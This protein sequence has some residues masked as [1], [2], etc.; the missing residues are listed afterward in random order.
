MGYRE[1][2]EVDIGE[3][4]RRWQAGESQRG[5]A[6]ATGV[7]RN[8]VA[9]YLEL[10]GQAG[11]GRERL[12]TEAELASLQAHS[13]LPGRQRGPNEQR[14][15]Q[16][17]AQLKTWVCRERLQLTRVHELL[18]QRLQLRV[19][20]MALYR[21]VV[22]QGWLPSHAGT[23]RMATT[24]PGEVAEVDFGYLGRLAEPDSAWL[25]KAWAFVVV[26][27]FSRHMHVSI[28]FKQDV[29]AAIAALEAAW[30]FFGG[31]VRRVVL[32]NFR[33]AVDKA[34][35]YDPL[36]NRTL[37]EYSQHRG[38]ILDPTRVRHP[39]DKPHTERSVPFVRERLY[40]GGTFRD[41]D[42]ANR[43]AAA[44]CLTVA[45]QRTHGT[46]RLK[47]LVAFEQMEKGALLPWDGVPYDVPR[48]ARPK[49][50]PDYHLQFDKALYSVPERYKGQR[51]DVRGDRQL[52]RIYAGAVLVKTHPR[53]PPGGRSTDYDD[54]PAHRR[55]YALRAPEDCIRRGQD[56]GPAIGR[57]LTAL[58][59]GEFPWAKLRQAYKCLRLVERYGAERVNA[60]C[61]RAVSYGLLN[62][63]RVERM[64][65]LELE[66]QPVD[67]PAS[68]AEPPPGRFARPGASFSQ[69]QLF[70]ERP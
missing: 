56:Q 25:R 54:Y 2:R 44:W 27:P 5:I 53:Q 40:K 47:P 65:Q 58:L 67:T 36:L 48:W 50:A 32:D 61:E 55:P 57:F 28:A 3:V 52:V 62:V 68:P 18:E 33:A 39:R 38:F 12:A 69:T 63:F 51:M 16:H 42:D 45:G 30:A 64:L 19:S 70:E 13:Q 59:A 11:I 14:L 43:Q 46:T 37:A 31:S 35:N 49:V 17:T 41:I 20:Y 34:D 8:T 10:A 23:V 6:A 24:R 60:A 66:H 7:S 15:S 9:K 26:L 1:V 22:A 4:L 29:P 21:Y